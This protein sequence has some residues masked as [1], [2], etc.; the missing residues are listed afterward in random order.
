MDRAGNTRIILHV[1]MDSFFAS[2]E[3]REHPGLAG[4]PVVVGADP[5]EGRGRGV[6]STCSYEARKFGIHSAMPI[7]RA[8][9]LCPEAVFLRPHFPL[10]IRA[11]EKIMQILR[12][13]ADRFE[14]VSIDEAYLDL[15][16]LD[17]WQEAERISKRIKERIRGETG[18]TCS[19]GVGPGKTVAKIASDMR[20]PDG[21][22][23]VRP[24]EAE[25]FLAPLPVEKIPGIG[26]KTAAGLRNIGIVRI[27]D[28]ASADIQVLMGILG[29]AAVPLVTLSRGIDER[30]VEEGECI[31][32]I[33]R[34]TTF[35]RD[36]KDINTLL[37]V[38]DD[39][40]EDL[41]RELEQ[42]RALCGTVTVRIRFPDFSTYTRSRT[43][44]HPAR[45]YRVLS[46]IGREL[47]C[48]LLDGRSVRLLGLRFSSLLK[49]G[50]DQRCLSDF[51]SGFEG[52]KGPD[53]QRLSPDRQDRDQEIREG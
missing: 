46:T 34:E 40:A 45:D 50:G 36:V 5:M 20:K 51:L 41:V 21:L 18:L 22:L 32:S 4:K 38:L 37:S 49:L 8:F 31:K 33:S 12:Q 30:P 17:D 25:Q 2:V 6:V 14:Q 13:S 52:S 48:P 35:E 15:S 43:L 19:I 9:H 23:L 47:A 10:Y 44:L 42:D 1:D 24:K 11:S 26:K 7:S 3:T 16:S 28:L 27:G 29:R 39:L 53:T